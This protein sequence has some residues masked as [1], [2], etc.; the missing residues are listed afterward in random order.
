MARALCLLHALWLLGHVAAPAAWA[1]NL[2][3][4]RITVYTGPNGS[5]FGFSVDFHKDSHMGVAVVVGAPRAR[6]PDQE[7]TGAV[8]LCPWS[9]AGG[10]CSSLLFDLRESRRGARRGDRVGVRA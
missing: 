9:A 10:S 6:G 7:E 4:A 1:L 2:D 8:F 3:A 5:H